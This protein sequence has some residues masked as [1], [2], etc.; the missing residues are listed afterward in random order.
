MEVPEV[1][2]LKL[3]K[4]ENARFKRLLAE[5]MCYAMGLSQRR[6]GLSLSICRYA[7]QR[8][9][10]DAQLSVRIT[11]L[12]LWLSAYLEASSARRLLR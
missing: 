3:H 8:P 11:E 7:D 5:A 4:E 1:K 10:A 6:A 2:R 12:A 9:A